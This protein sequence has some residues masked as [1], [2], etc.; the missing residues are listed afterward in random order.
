M[1][2]N[3]VFT[4]ADVWTATDGCQNTATC[5]RI[6]TWTI[7]IDPPE[8]TQCPPDM[9]IG[10]NPWP[11][12]G[13]SVDEVIAVDDCG[14][15]VVT[16]EK[17]T[18]A[19]SGC[20]VTRTDVWT[21]TDG[22]QNTQTCSRTYTWRTN[23][24]LTEEMDLEVSIRKE[25]R[26]T[27]SGEPT[28]V[29]NPWC[30]SL[31]SMGGDQIV[32]ATLT[33]PPASTLPGGILAF[34]ETQRYASFGEISAAMPNGTYQ[35]DMV[36]TAAEPGTGTVAVTEYFDIDRSFPFTNHAPV[37]Q[38]S[39]WS[40]DVLLVHQSM[41]QSWFDASASYVTPAIG[42]FSRVAY[43][44]PDDSLWALHVSSSR[45]FGSFEALSGSEVYRAELGSVKSIHMATAV[46][47]AEFGVVY[48]CVTLFDVLVEPDPIL[49]SIQPAPGGLQCTVT[50]LLPSAPY[51]V[52]RAASPG[53]PWV[54]ADSFVAPAQTHVV[55]LP[56]TVSHW[57]VFRI[58]VAD[59]L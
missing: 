30:V 32:D 54:L 20:V 10:S 7:D 6:Y 29:A 39:T 14:T 11:I 46:E 49:T 5:S 59:W 44:A 58:L 28:L 26:Q 37:V 38:F 17:G 52:Y 42:L 53:N 51:S 33:A 23:T 13:A 12:P 25:Y 31:R 21:A 40:N 50:G 55:F 27:D 2:S 1:Q 48:E 24:G 18:P 45:L 8:F 19:Y 56:A 57:G 22:C 47:C 16:V 41:D 35:L 3:C 9:D 4:R 43:Y 15:P 36:I 34:G